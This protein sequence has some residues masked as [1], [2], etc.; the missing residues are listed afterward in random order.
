MNRD[1]SILKVLFIGLFI[2]LLGSS[3]VSAANPDGYV[4]A[5]NY[6]TFGDKKMTGGVGSY[7]NNKRYY[8]TYGL[9]NTFKGFAANAVSEWVNTS[10]GY[11]YV[12]TS[13]SIRETTNRSAAMFEFVN[14]TLPAGI[15]GLTTFWVYSTQIYT[16]SVGALTQNYGWTQMLISTDNMIYYG[17]PASKCKGTFA[18]ELGHSMGLSHQ[19]NNPY[20]IMCQ[21]YYGRIVQRAEAIDCN[22]INH[23]Y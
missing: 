7:G 5:H 9:N 10:P 22:A 18:H 11:P 20:S 3:I 19:N 23:L 13:I 21:D 12:T 2:F 15:L 6:H 17:V 14:A 4:C 1:K 8:W 16:N